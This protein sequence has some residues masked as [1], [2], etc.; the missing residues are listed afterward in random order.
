MPDCIW[1]VMLYA[2]VVA[3]YAAGGYIGAK[4]GRRV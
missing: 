2:S 4:W 1:I 3:A